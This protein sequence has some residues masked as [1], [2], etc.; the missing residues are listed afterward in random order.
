MFKSTTFRGCMSFADHAA[1]S[2]NEYSY[3]TDLHACACIIFQ[4]DCNRYL[5]YVRE[6]EQTTDNYATVVEKG[7]PSGSNDCLDGRVPL[8][9]RVN[10]SRYHNILREMLNGNCDASSFLKDAAVLKRL[11]DFSVVSEDKYSCLRKYANV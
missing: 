9:V 2:R 3:K 10:L 7:Y 6:M 5:Q 4:L 11:S 8:L 1:L